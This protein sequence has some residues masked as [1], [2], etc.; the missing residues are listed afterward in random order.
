VGAR[1][2]LGVAAQENN[3]L[4]V[5]PVAQSHPSSDMFMY[6]IKLKYENKLYKFRIANLNP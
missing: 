1:Y 3:S 2:G 5:D 4:F 6:R